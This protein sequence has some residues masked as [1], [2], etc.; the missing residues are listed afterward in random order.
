M[1]NAVTH[2]ASPEAQPF[3]FLLASS[4]R[5][6]LLWFP[7]TKRFNLLSINHKGAASRSAALYFL[8]WSCEDS[9]NNNSARLQLLRFRRIWKDEWRRARFKRHFSPKK[10]SEKPRKLCNET[11]FL[12]SG[13][14]LCSASF[15]WIS[16]VFSSTC[17]S[18]MTHKHRA[19]RN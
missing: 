15:Q 6:N 19:R 1:L 4:S 3:E 16:L 11:A 13:L 5:L 12:C 8:G 2:N 9:L 10:E 14:S 17:C 18:H 7:S